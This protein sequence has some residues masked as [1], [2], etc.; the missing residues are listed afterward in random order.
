MGMDHY[1]EEIKKAGLLDKDSD[2]GGMVGEALLKLCEC[3]VGEGHS[4]FSHGITVSAF[5]QLMT[6]GI[7]TPLTGEDS[8]WGDVGNGL[9]QNKRASN[10]FKTANGSA[11]QVDYYIFDDGE[12]DSWTGKESSKDIEFP[13]MPT[14]KRIVKGTVEAEQFKSVFERE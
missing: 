7:L 3:M 11:Y 10:V 6:T 8:E 2:Y 4:G 9:F 14:H 12:G 5:H 1:R 13:F